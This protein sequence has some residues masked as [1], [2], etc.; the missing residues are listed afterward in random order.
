MSIHG[1]VGNI[2][3]ANP[4]A[5]T[6]TV[7]SGVWTTEQQLAAKSAGNWPFTI[8]TQQIGSSL[9]FN[10]ADTAYL[11]RTFSTGNR[12]TW[13]W[14]GWVK[15][16][17]LGTE[18]FV[19]GNYN[20]T[21]GGAAGIRFEPD[22][23][24][25]FY[26]FVGAFQVQRATTQ[27]FRD[28]S[29]WYHIVAILD[30][31]QATASD[32]AKLYVNGTQITAFSATTNPTQNYDGVINYNDQHEISGIVVSGLSSAFDGYLTE[33]NFIDGQALT[34]SSF[35]RTSTTT[36]VWEPLAY[37]GTYGTNGFYVN[38]SDNSGTTSTTLGKDYSGNGNNWTPNN[39][40]VTAGAG[41]DSLVDSPT[42]YGTD[43]GVGGEV[44]GNYATWNPLAT[45]PAAPVTFSNGNLDVSFGSSLTGRTQSTLG[46][47][48]GKWYAEI[49]VTAAS[50]TDRII[51]IVTPT[52]NNQPG[53]TA[54][55]YGYYGNGQKITNDTLTSYGASY[56]A[57]DVIGIALD[58]D[59]GTI[60][61]YK[62][63]T[64]QG[65]A[66]SGLSGT[67]LISVSDSSNAG[68]CSYTANFG[69]R[70][71]A[72]TAPSGFKA[73]CTTNLP[74]PTIGATSTTQ[75][76]D[77]F[78]VTTYSGSASSQSI[79]NSGSMQ[80]DFVWIK[81][82]N[83]TDS[84][85]LTDAV[86]GTN[87]NL[88]SNLTNA[89][90][91]VARLTSFNSNGVTLAGGYGSTNNSGQTY[92]AWQWNA[93]GSTVTNTSGTISAQVRASTI[94]G[95]SIITYTG[96]GTAGA[97]VGHGLGV[98]PDMIIV[99]SRSVGTG[100][101]VVWHSSLTSSNN[102]YLL[103]N[104]TA[105]VNTANQPWNNTLPTSSVFSLRTW[106]S[107]NQNGSTYVAYCFDAVAGYSAFGSYTG[108]GSTDGTF[109]Y[110]G[111]RPRYVLVK[112]F[113]NAENWAIS[114]T[115]RSPYN[116]ANAFLRPDESSAETTGAMLMDFLS[117]GFKLRTTDT[118][119]NGSG[120]S[121][122][123]AAFA[124]SPFK[125]ALAR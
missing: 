44:R 59:A 6:S 78:D 117:N 40:S 96:N 45:T 111:F 79:T 66:F 97:T 10:S 72:Y 1:Y 63:N 18:Q 113:N 20:A 54:D 38:F 108:N 110:T 22:N 35:G 23:T 46:V 91:T 16:G 9:R 30:T 103:L 15:R 105:A 7:A 48:S 125:Y 118:K 60:T 71:F 32:R 95:V 27:V 73:L 74:T 28:P 53:Y 34:P 67:Y 4:T 19:F 104:S 114:D 84:H 88:F 65:Q 33:V 76:N 121:Y 8:P 124:E 98:T 17:T 106:D 64:S 61:F 93:G 70:A 47:S 100:D 80:P 94:S 26:N 56:T 55:S 86:R 90:D 99:K 87:K 68:T 83:T 116:A 21:L 115:S 69:Q 2:I 12:R 5:P 119:S 62:N 120:Y 25:I 81:S 77:Y 31:T 39:F 101:W 109:V 24:I 29:A 49:T 85:N 75:A 82:R 37:T 36:G 112:S 11:S 13:T 43:T 58:L 89:E 107:V 50:G 123:Y 92:V 52:T 57:N 3:T 102:N 51:G 122:I 41:N 14:S 42:A